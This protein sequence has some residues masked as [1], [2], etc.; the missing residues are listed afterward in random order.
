MENS[1]NSY[2]RTDNNKIINERCIVWVKKMNDCLMSNL[3]IN[4]NIILLPLV[5]T[6]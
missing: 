3:H 1:T 5:V 2:V 4:F 6:K